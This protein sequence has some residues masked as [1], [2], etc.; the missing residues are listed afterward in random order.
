MLRN[1]ICTLF[2]ALPL[3]VTAQSS[4]NED[5]LDYRR[6][7]M[8]S[9]LR[10][11]HP[12]KPDDIAYLRFYDINPAYQVNAYF[13]LVSGAKPFIIRTEHGGIKKAVREYGYVYFNLMGAS[14]KLYVYR[15]LDMQNNTD[16]SDQLFIPFTD[17]TNYKETFR[18]GRYLDLSVSDIKDGRV[19]IDFNKCYNPHTAYEM[20]YPYIVPP[21]DNSLRIA[22]EA[23]EKIFGHNPG[24]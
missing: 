13:E 8:Q 18:G 4:Y 9:L 2:L 20:G 14:V 5:M 23:G 16:R 15:F 24:Y 22:I 12:L 19:I 21:D 7:Y 3:M 1:F 11:S 17:R 10:G 6:A